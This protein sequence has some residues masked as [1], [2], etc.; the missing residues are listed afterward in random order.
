MG[1]WGA[2]SFQ[3]DHARD[4]LSSAL[5]QPVWATVAVALSSA[6]TARSRDESRA[7]AG[8][9]IV[10]AAAHRPSASLPEEAAKL[11]SHLGRPSGELVTLAKAACERL[12]GESELRELWDDDAEWRGEMTNLIERLSR[13]A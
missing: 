10:A 6:D 2:R 8:A 1:T 4:W 3:N 13:I 9:E 12:L 11:A 7:V 5:E